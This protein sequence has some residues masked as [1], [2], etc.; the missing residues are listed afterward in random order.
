MPTLRAPILSCLLPYVLSP[1]S[2]WLGRAEADD[3]PPACPAERVVRRRR[4]AHPAAA[5][6]RKCHT[7]ALLTQG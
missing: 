3:M 6:R 5:L 1:A 7:P 2:R 4:G